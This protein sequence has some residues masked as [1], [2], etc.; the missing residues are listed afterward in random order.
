MKNIGLRDIRLG[1]DL[2]TDLEHMARLGCGKFVLESLPAALYSF[3]S[4]PN[5]FERSLLVAVN[6]GGDTDSI[7]AMAGALSGTF[8][9]AQSI[10]MRWVKDLEKKEYLIEMAN[11]LYDLATEGKPRKIPKWPVVG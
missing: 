5:N 3:L 1:Y 2:D 8:N 4:S 10:P 11:L 6:A 9:G 7:G